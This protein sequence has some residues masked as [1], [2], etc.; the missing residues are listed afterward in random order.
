MSSVSLTST[1]FTRTAVGIDAL[2]VTG[3]GGCEM[4]FFETNET[5]G[6]G[7]TGGR[8]FRTAGEWVFA[9]VASEV[10]RVSSAL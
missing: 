9:R 2:V 1:D 10:H 7:K 4:T 8:R 5:S 3:T 6:E